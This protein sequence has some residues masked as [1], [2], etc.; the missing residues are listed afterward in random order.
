MLKVREYSRKSKYKT[1]LSLSVVLLVPGYRAM[2][3]LSYCFTTI[4]F[5]SD[6]DKTESCQVLKNALGRVSQEYRNGK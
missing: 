1:H 3:G 2:G 5:S 6:N 4:R